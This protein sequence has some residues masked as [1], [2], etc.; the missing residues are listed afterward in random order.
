MS[1]NIGRRFFIL[2]L[3]LLNGLLMTVIML[4]FLIL[5]HRASVQTAQADEGEHTHFRFGHITW[6]LDE[7]GPPNTAKITFMA[8]F[9]R[10]G[11]A[12]RDPLTNSVVPCTGPG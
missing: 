11:F 6:E 1:P 5:T 12:C 3:A 8:G 7:T 4:L 2:A 9:R 10:S